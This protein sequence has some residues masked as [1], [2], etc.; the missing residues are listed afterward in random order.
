[1]DEDN[2]DNF[3]LI[4]PEYFS[5]DSE[6]HPFIDSDKQQLGPTSRKRTLCSRCTL[7]MESA[8]ICAGLPTK[9]IQ[10]KKSRVIV[11]QH[12]H[13]VKRKNRSL[14]LVEH[15]LES[16]STDEGSFSLKVVIGR[17]LGK[18]V[19]K[20]VMEKINDD[21]SCLLIYPDSDALSIEQGLEELETRKMLRIK[22]T[23][24]NQQEHQFESGSDFDD[25]V[26]LIFIDATWKHSKEMVDINTFRELWP[27]NLIRVKLSAMQEHETFVPRRFDIRCP[28][29][30]EH[31][32][33]AECIAWVLAIVERD[34]KACTSIIEAIDYMV[35]RW[36]LYSNAR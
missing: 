33:T 3:N 10:L 27:K 6:K 36:H 12:P 30:P 8:C 21:C 2:N 16:C 9:K 13:E 15:C 20:E 14:P 11:L 25:R 32:S 35:S 5:D 31:L 23:L 4:F 29:S 18:S 28:P 7:P 19:D 26:T 1:M 22:Q 24:Q 34:D 17:R